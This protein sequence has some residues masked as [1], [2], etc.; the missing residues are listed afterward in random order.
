MDSFAGSS[1][2]C[3]ARQLEWLAL[4]KQPSQAVA[5]IYVMKRLHNL[6]KVMRLIKVSAL[7]RVQ[8][9]LPRVAAAPDCTHNHSSDPLGHLLCVLEASVKCNT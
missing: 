1:K 3:V 6:V 7:V 9:G 5:L 2:L 8:L 4:N